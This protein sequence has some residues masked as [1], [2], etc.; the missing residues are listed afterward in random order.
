LGDLSKICLVIPT[1]RDIDWTRLKHVPEEVNIKVM[2]DKEKAPKINTER[3]NVEFYSH[4]D[5]PQSLVNI[6]SK[7]SAACV[8]YVSLQAYK[9]GFDKILFTHDDC[10]VPEDWVSEYDRILGSE[11]KVEHVTSD[12][13]WYNTFES[14]NVNG[15][16]RGY[17]HLL[18]D[19]LEHT[20]KEMKDSKK[21]MAHMGFWS[22]HL[23]LD[24]IGKNATN[25]T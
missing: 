25:S 16:Q 5:V 22:N 13:G 23:D 24:G 2:W 19:G 15:F 1:I 6:V 14:L 21:I 10:V 17:P 8:N 4:S 12:N 11:Q 7:G 18:R 3:K 20:T 9:E